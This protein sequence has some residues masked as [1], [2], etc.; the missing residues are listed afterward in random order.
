MKYELDR[1][2]N[3]LIILPQ[4]W[5]PQNAPPDKRSYWWVP[6]VLDRVFQIS[7]RSRR[8][9]NAQSTI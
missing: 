6:H 1:C 3:R 8:K 7:M 9:S 4:N 2:G 5:R